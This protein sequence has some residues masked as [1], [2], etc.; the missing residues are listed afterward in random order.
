MRDI[1][2]DRIDLRS[3]TVTLLTLKGGWGASHFHF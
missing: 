2:S 1:V 3:D